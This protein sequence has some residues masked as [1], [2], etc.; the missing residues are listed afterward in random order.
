ME[1][2]RAI[3]MKAIRKDDLTGTKR[4]TFLH[5]LS[6]GVA[7]GAE[8]DLDQVVIFTGLVHEIASGEYADVV[9]HPTRSWE[10]IMRIATWVN[11]A[12]VANRTP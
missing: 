6:S 11:G 9:N 3:V 2:A 5:H 1:K 8:L 7:E 12:H 4:G 10:F